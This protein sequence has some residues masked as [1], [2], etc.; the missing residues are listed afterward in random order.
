MREGAQPSRFV[1]VMRFIR[2]LCFICVVTLCAVPAAFGKETTFTF[3]CSDKNDLYI[4]ARH[5]GFRVKRF[6][7]PAEAVSAAAKGSPVLI[8]ADEYPKQTTKI[9]ADIFDKAA[10]KELRLFVEYPESIPGMQLSKPHSTQWERGVV[11]DDVFGATL[12]KF[13][14]VAVHDCHFLPCKADRPWLVV[15]RV[16]GFDTA[17]Y[18]LP[19]NASPLLFEFPQRRM[20]VATTK[21][22][23]FITARYAPTE[24]WK[25]IWQTI[26]AKLDPNGGTREL[27][28][29]PNVAPAYT[30]NEKLPRNAER[31]AFN[32]AAKWIFNSKLLVTE[33]RTNEI[34][35][36]LARNAATIA[37]PE[38]NKPSD[39]RFGIQEGYASGIQYDG[40]QLQN[41]PLRADCNIESAMVLALN[42]KLNADKRSIDVARNLLDFVYFNSGMCAGPRADEKHGAFG[43]IGWGDISPAWLVANY[44]DDNARAMLGT[45]IAAA[46]LG[47]P[48]WNEPLAK[49]LLANYRTTGKFGFRGDRIDIPALASGW[50]QFYNSEVINYSPHFEAYLWACN[51]WTYRATGDRRFLDR[52]T[53][54]IA[55]TMKVY[56]TGWRW[57]D[58]SE[59]A[60]ILLSLAWLVRVQDTPEHRQWL[61]SVANDLLLRQQPNGAIHEWLAGTGGGHYHIPTSNEAYGTG[62]TPL[63][64]NNGDPAS[65][66]LYTTGFALLG[67]HEAVA[68]TGDT[69]LKEAEDRL[70]Q[71]LCRVQIRSEKVPYLNGWWFRAF[72]DVRWDY[73]ASSADAGWGAWSIEAG[74]AQAWTATV[75]ALRH[76]K[77]TVWE[78]TSG[79]GVKKDI[80][81]WSEKMLQ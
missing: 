50:K 79:V 56:P 31:N 53:N 27:K 38:E 6:D 61:N 70:A 21:L 76:N 7:T 80:Q 11:S 63:I 49:A 60:Q 47:D 68:A 67:L 41:L 25:T 35:T 74:W 18:G 81:Q 48:K 65:D 3:C 36:L 14:I 16:A 40:S 62:E 33:N 2:T 75:M 59:R 20:I 32:A 55:M 44:G 34:T 73:W 71:F 42:A 52:T 13:R 4:T 22:S 64:Q 54:A 58:N 39:G 72:D 5:S 37:A 8:L 77:T 57:G 28:W 19:S 10:E 29:T 46:A 43:T 78:M 17:P 15:A 1:T 51:L 69:K 66:Q 45:M 12:L 24:A 30:A 23:Q 26:F 9:D